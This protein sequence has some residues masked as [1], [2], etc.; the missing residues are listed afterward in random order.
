MKNLHLAIL[1]FLGTA[2]TANAQLPRSEPPPQRMP[3]ISASDDD[4]LFIKSIYDNT[5]TRS[6]CYEWLRHLCK[7][8]GNRVSGSEHYLAAVEYTRQML[9]SLGLDTVWIQPVMVPHWERGDVEKAR[10]ISQFAGTIDLN[11]A[12]LGGS[13]ATP[14]EG[15]NAE[16]IEVKSLDELEALGAAK[17][18]GK[19]VFFNRPMDPTQVNT[20]NAY[21]G[22]VDQRGSGPSLASELGAVAALT[23]SMTLKYDD[24]PHSGGTRFGEGIAPIPAAALG[25]QSAEM[26]SQL[27]KKEPNLR[28][29]IRLSCRKG[30][31]ELAYSVIGEIKGS[32]YPND[33]IV[34]GGHLD[35]WDIG[36]GAHDDGA[37]CV[38]SMEVVHLFKRMGIRPQHTIRC[39]LFANEENGTRGGN[40]YAEEAKRKKEHHIAA[41]ESDAGGHAPVGFSIDGTEALIKANL[42]QVGSWRSLLEPYGSYKLDKG[43]SGVDIGPLRE[44]NVLLFGMMPESQRYFDYHHSKNDVFENVNKRELELGAASMS[45]LVWLLD[46]Y[47]VR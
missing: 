38:Q 46:T 19:I 22:A 40:K 33:I 15:L 13:A 9:D 14:L 29:H 31:D 45:A 10:A 43:H 37:G 35:S 26:L 34:V 21:S 4:A 6:V 47:G 24:A 30:K 32:K 27:L 17:V 16:V 5:L 2:F 44:Q 18:K 41:I 8:V 11:I 23:R 7:K 36:E 3:I 28:V 12:A 1:L 20:F 39:V 42:P 25:I